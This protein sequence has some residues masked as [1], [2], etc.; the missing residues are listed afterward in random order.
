MRSDD[1][2]YMAFLSGLR[3]CS[4]CGH[5]YEV[6]DCESNSEKRCG[7]CQVAFRLR[8]SDKPV[9]MTH[10]DWKWTRLFREHLNNGG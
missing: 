5:A 3:E 2:R 10:Q 6:R 9:G 1:D 7:A 4:D 8:G